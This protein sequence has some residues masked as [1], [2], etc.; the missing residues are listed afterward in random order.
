MINKNKKLFLS[1]FFIF[2]ILILIL[3]SFVSAY[4]QSS[5]SSR[6]N[7]AIGLGMFSGGQSLKVDESMCKQG[8]DFII[9]IGPL[10]CTPTLVRSDL[11]EEENVNVF[12]KMTALQINPFIDVKRID[13]IGFVKE[14]PREVM[15]IG[16]QPAQAALGYTQDNLEGSLGLE[17]LGYVMITLR[18]Q[19][20]ESALTNCEKKALGGEIC[21]VEGNLTANLRYDIQNIF[22]VGKAVFYLPVMDDKDWQDNYVQYTFWGGRGYL[23]AESL[24]EEGASLSVYSDNSVASSLLRTGREYNLARY[25]S[26]IALK[27]GETSNKIFLPGL[28]PCLASL[29]LELK[30]IENPDTRAVI[31]INEDYTEVARRETFLE[32][33]CEVIDMKK[34][35]VTSEVEIRCKDAD[36]S[37][38]RKPFYLK[39]YPKVNLSVGGVEKYYGIGE[40]LYKSEDGEK[41]IYLGYIGSVGQATDVKNLYITLVALPINEKEGDKDFLTESE[42][43]SVAS[44]VETRMASPDKGSVGANKVSG[45]FNA[46]A[47]ITMRVGKAVIKGENFVNVLYKE[48]LKKE[49]TFSGVGKEYI[50]FKGTDVVLEGFS[51]GINDGILPLSNTNYTNAT[52]DFDRVINNYA[53]EMKKTNSI[54]TLGEEALYEKIYLANKVGKKKTLIELCKEFEQ[55]YPNSYASLDICY[56][57]LKL[58]SNEASVKEITMNGITKRISFDGIKEP[59]EDDYSA[60]LIVKGPHGEILPYVLEKDKAIMLSGFRTEEEEKKLGSSEY[61][62]LK[63]LDTNSAK[64]RIHVAGNTALEVFLSDDKT[65]KVGESK[66]YNGYTITLQKINLNKVAKVSVI[67]NKEF[68]RSNSSFTFKIGVEKRAI[69]LSPQKA[70]E[71][72]ISQNKSIEDLQKISDSLYTTVKTMKTACIGAEAALTLKNLIANRDGK[73]IARQEAMSVAGGWNDRCAKD[74]DSKKYKTLDACFLANA[75]DIEKEVDSKYEIIKFQNNELANIERE[76]TIKGSGLIQNTLDNK[77]YINN[78]SNKVD[79]SL[80]S[81]NVVNAIGASA[82]LTDEQKKNLNLEEITNIINSEDGTSYENYYEKNAYTLDQLKEI[83]FYSLYI[84][85]NPKDEAAIKRLYSVLSDVKVNSEKYT[86]TVNLVN[87]MGIEDKDVTLM[88]IKVDTRK[89]VYTGKTKGN[90]KTNIPDMPANT[91]IAIVQAPPLGNYVFVLDNSVGSNTYS[92]KEIYNIDGTPVN[93]ESSNYKELSN[94]R[95]EKFDAT[96]Y[97]NEYK[98]SY[99]TSE[100]LLRYYEIAPYKGLPA[101]VP[102]DIKNGWYAGIESPQTSYDASGVIKNFYLCNVAE[103]KIEEFQ[104]TN[105]KFGD[106]I[107]QLILLGNVEQSYTFFSKLDPNKVKE[108]VGQARNA[109]E[110]AQRSRANNEGLTYVKIVGSGSKNKNGIKVGEPPVQS[111]SGQCTDFMSAK[112]CNML[113]NV[114]DPVVCPSSRCNFGGKFPVQ[115]VMQTG[116][117]GSIALCYPNAKWEGG[118]VYIPVCLSGVQTGLD[119]WISIK[120]SYVDCLQKSIDTGETVGICDEINSI[121]T[122]EFFWKQS[123]PLIKYALPKL[124]AKVTG[125]SGKGGGEYNGITSALDS[126]KKSIDYF[127]QYYAD[128]SYR[129]FQVRS[130]EEVGTEICG[131][132]ISAIYPDEG[133]FLDN[134]ITPDSP[135]QFT[136]KF[137]ETQQTTVTNPP[138]SHYKVYYHIY[139]GKDSGAYYTVYLRGSGSSYYQ[140]TVQNRLVKSSYIAKGGYASETIDFTAPSGYQK[141]CIVVNGQEECGF[142]EVSTSFA[143]NYLSDLYLTEQSTTTNIKTEKKCI[144][145]T[146]SLYSL[147]DLNIESMGENLFDPTLYAQGIIRICAT[148]DPGAGTDILNGQ[149]GSRWK[150]VGYCGNSRIGCWIDTDSVKDAIKAIN[151]EEKALGEISND[152]L[153][154]L[155]KDYFSQDEFNKKM[156]E[157]NAEGI[158]NQQ[159][160]KIIT[161]ALKSNKIFYNNQK[162]QLFFWRGKAYSELAIKDY[163]IV[164]EEIK[165]KRATISEFDET[166]TSPVLIFEDGKI[167]TTNIC[168]KYFNAIWHWTGSCRDAMTAQWTEVDKLEDIF[169]NSPNERNKIYI[170]SLRGKYYLDGLKVLVDRT[171]AKEEG[172]LLNA[173]L[174]AGDSIMSNLGI[175]S[176]DLGGLRITSIYYEYIGGNWRWSP[177]EENWM[178]TDV[179]V[180]KGGKYDKQEPFQGN[181][182]LI[183]SL[184]GKNLYEGAAILFD[185]ASSAV[186]SANTIPSIIVP[187]IIISLEDSFAKRDQTKLTNLMK[188]LSTIGFASNFMCY[189][190]DNCEDYAQWIMDVSKEEYV[191][192]RQN[193]PDELLLLAVMIQESSCKSVKSF[194]GDIGLMQINARVHCGTKGLGSISGDCNSTLLNDNEKNINVGAQILRESYRTSGK[195]FTCGITF[196]SYSGWEAA[197]RGY[198][199]WGCTGNNNYVEEVET[200]YFELVDLYNGNT[201]GITACATLEKKCV[202]KTYFT[203][204]NNVWTSQGEVPGECNVPSISVAQEIFLVAPT[205][206]QRI[207]QNTNVYYKYDSDDGWQ[208]TIND[209]NAKIWMPITTIS[210]TGQSIVIPKQNVAIIHS[211]NGKNYADGKKILKDGGATMADGSEIVLSVTSGTG[212][213]SGGCDNSLVGG[214]ILTFAQNNI[215]RDTTRI[216]NDAVVYDNVCATFVS[217]VLI[218]AGLFQE[219]KMCSQE[220]IPYRDAIVELIDLFEK[221]GFVEISENNWKS[222]LKKGDLIIWGGSGSYDKIY[223]HITIFSEYADSGAGITV[224]HDGGKG[225]DISYKTYSNP[226]GSDW[227]VT[228]VWRARCSVA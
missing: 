198:N 73:A 208:W 79:I 66:T 135:F 70:Q 76:N 158:T 94:C 85:D 225:V 188:S 92:V 125:Q 139:S 97:E 226:F 42:I 82:S 228:H 116:I 112:D 224:V 220:T 57:Y 205:F 65:L 182:N 7:N 175:F 128:D 14:Y 27:P 169:G 59:S 219:F 109:I 123:I 107:C 213:T 163:D 33:K 10:S 90:T 145:G 25:S 100:P 157:I 134:L 217:N 91:P 171:L 201:G 55:S 30:G 167:G 12:C 133:S 5:F 154:Y 200:K 190:G 71:K 99:G 50:S 74:V 95:F 84:E 61:L 40:F 49:L 47:G 69:Q 176:V 36:E 168:Y 93:K 165:A 204:L 140:D 98:S 26:N 86:Q 24:D 103:N 166:Y 3:S 148:D 174:K 191:S 37:I 153:K 53:G 39:I 62:E 146:V 46:V 75:E 56:D 216:E 118:D 60:E 114:C 21:W 16:Y 138:I 4:V 223:Q 113:F 19:P 121:Y 178:N 89:Y 110:V 192:G 28:S 130:T 22:G 101:V 64:I 142:K 67:S 2:G 144:S 179:L 115:N 51:E 196:N 161:D 184:K 185:P 23:R 120:R 78:Y 162:A 132:F 18:R 11:L 209:P 13:S 117:I 108:L 17:N 124:L 212:S 38:D 141:L 151:L 156:E 32:G 127:K 1:M 143:V 194:G 197:L 9:Q 122:C 48:T 149:D 52:E 8:S 159:I 164:F 202:G 54:Q 83:E 173:D 172:G 147:L 41:Y 111:S 34:T 170:T 152:T 206:F 199:G 35:G 180:V 207:T 137:E 155:S 160:I 183:N 136:G 177:D 222:G 181:K 77:G 58:S 203:C 189:C 214:K 106:D 68:A 43:S 218:E 227:F 20:N 211:L 96:S 119:N 104:L 63:E 187:P 105:P 88:Q 80:N 102:F 72:I 150:K 45:L 29:Q 193:I 215:G 44:W 15:S 31:K 210:V 126:A 87:L 195:S 186:K 221:D 129:A 131:S 6:N 81:P